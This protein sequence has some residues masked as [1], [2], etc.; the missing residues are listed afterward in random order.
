LVGQI[1]AESAV[2]AEYRREIDRICEE[3]FIALISRGGA[4]PR[5]EDRARAA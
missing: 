5:C 2:Y 4:S 1:G 3:E